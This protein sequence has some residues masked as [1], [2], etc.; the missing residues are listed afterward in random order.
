[1]LAVAKYTHV[2]ASPAK[3]HVANTPVVASTSQG[4]Q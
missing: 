3:N 1:M 4:N 2:A